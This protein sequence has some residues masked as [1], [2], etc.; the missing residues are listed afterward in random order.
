MKRVLKQLII[1]LI[2]TS[3]LLSAQATKPLNDAELK[4]MIAR[5]IIIG[6]DDSSIDRDSSIVRDLQNYPLGGVILFDRFFDDR[7][8]VKNISSPEQLQALCKKLQMFAKAPLFISVDQEGGK[9]AR[10]KP[11]YGFSETPSAFSISKMSQKEVEYL[12]ARESYMLKQA[13]INMNFA[14]VVDLAINPKNS[15][16]VGL[17][18]SYGESVEEVVSRA[19]TLIEK[20]K[21]QNIISVAKHFPGHGSSLGDSHEG[22]VDI[23][24]TWSKKELLPYEYLINA[25]MIDMIMTAHVFNKMLDE[26]LPATLSYRVNT[27]ILRDKLKYRGVIV[28]DDMQ[29]RAIAANYPLK[30]SITLAIN[31]G[32]DMLL[33]GNQLSSITLQELIDIIYAQVKSGAISLWRIEESNARIEHLHA[34]YSLAKEPK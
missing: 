7:E 25:E 27:D 11:Q 29:M 4:N 22:F 2:F 17:E 28:S 5:M 33:F 10:L 19:S 23:T 3:A 9:V 21:E 8:R 24:N 26:K 13:G 6:F 15:V 30:E 16:I 20:Q 1:T 34:K 12:Y 18:R 31:A 14:P 32:V